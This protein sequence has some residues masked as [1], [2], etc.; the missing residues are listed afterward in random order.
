MSK[1]IN[2]STINSESRCALSDYFFA[3]HSA[4]EFSVDKRETLDEDDNRFKLLKEAALEL[5]PDSMYEIYLAQ[6]KAE[7]KKAECDV[8]ELYTE[9]LESMGITATTPVQ[10]AKTVD[11]MHSRVCCVQRS[12][13]NKLLGTG[14]LTII[15][16]KTQFKN[17]F[18]RTL[19]S[20]FIDKDICKI[21]DDADN[22]DTLVWRT[23]LFD[24]TDA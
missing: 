8:Y 23:D 1:K 15:K 17:M 9:I 3:E 2:F 18:I 6:M 19:I 14:K 12:G 16:S 20:L 4:I 5:V 22:K 13:A 24:R 7:A 21:G 10:L 11:W